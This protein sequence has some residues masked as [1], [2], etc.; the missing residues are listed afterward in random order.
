VSLQ[1]LV[2]FAQTVKEGSFADAA[3]ELGLTPSAVAK[4]VARLEAELGLRLLHRT[5]RQVSLT[6][7]GHALYERCR[8]IVEEM[9]SL[10]A[11]AE[12]VRGEPAGKLRLNV[13][14]AF[15]KKVLVPLLARLVDRY[16]RVELDLTF[17]D[18][19]EDIIRSGFDAAVRVGQLV[20]ST[21][22]AHRFA[23]QQILVCASPGYIAQHGRPTAPG[24]LAGHRCM[25]FRM[26][27]AGRVRPWEFLHSGRPMTF[28][29]DSS[30]TMDDGEAL[31]AAAAGG[32]GLAQVPH[33]MAQDELDA[34]RLV[35]VLHA[36]RVPPMPI[37]L[38]YPSSRQV[39]PRLRALLEALTGR[40]ERSI[41]RRSPRSS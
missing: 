23:T 5:T 19:Y 22:I 16:P 15:G 33:Y 34:H 26:P 24:D 36:F 20:D 4:S 28:V 37:S 41:R 40:P 30:V 39:T 12:G 27:T 1:G 2:A 38:V 6:S 9:E 11:Q 8:R 18:R 14:T 35:E 31:V 3:R 10:R 29:P 17:S 21:L 25:L 7:D 13:P 32:L